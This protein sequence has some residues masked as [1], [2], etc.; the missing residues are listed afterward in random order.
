MD[1]TIEQGPVVAAPA[2]PQP[3][4]QRNA[5]SLFETV[6]S[7]LANMAPAEGIFVA[8]GLTVSFMG[9]RA[10]WAFLLSMIA[11]FTC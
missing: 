8:I 5:L 11:V 9:S 7:T 10:P 3:R 6:A 1:S 2:Q 4:L